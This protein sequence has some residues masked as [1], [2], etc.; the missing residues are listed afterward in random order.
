MPPSLDHQLSSIPPQV[1]DN[2]AL[3]YASDQAQ[4]D[5]VP[6]LVLFV[7][8]PQDYA[9]HD[10]GS[11]RIDFMLRNLVL[12]KVSTGRGI[13]YALTYALT[14]FRFQNARVNDQSILYK[15][16][17]DAFDLSYFQCLDVASEF[18]DFI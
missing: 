1:F 12:L 3:S 4:E 18:V 16:T 10:R 13:A 7:I 15:V 17:L 2:R 9:A 14:L 5:G 6:L 8:S 11:R